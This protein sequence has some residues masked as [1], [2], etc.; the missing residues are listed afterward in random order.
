M[1]DFGRLQ[2]LARA[3]GVQINPPL[4]TAIPMVSPQ[5]AA[6]GEV[7]S[8]TMGEWLGEP[9]SYAYAWFL[10]GTDLGALGSSYTP[11]AGNEGHSVTCV[12]T[13]TNTAGS[14]AAPPSNAVTVTAAAARRGPGE[15][16]GPEPAAHGPGRARPA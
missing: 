13:A 10:D 6:V 9:A 16:R 3:A 1:S 4:N 8:C 2:E 5:T 11:V 12:V 14:T 7:L 15:G